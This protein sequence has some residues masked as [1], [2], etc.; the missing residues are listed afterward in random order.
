MHS[1]GPDPFKVTADS[2][3]DSFCEIQKDFASLKASLD[4]VILSLLLKVH[5]S[6][7]GI[8]KEDQPVLNVFTKCSRFTETALKLVSQS[9]DGSPLNTEEL[10]VCLVAEIKYQQDEYAALLVKGK[11]DNSTAQLFRALQKN[12]ATMCIIA[13]FIYIFTKIKVSA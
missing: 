12:S 8:K 6:R 11:F 3:E 5:D 9:K 7:S 13:R 4:K 1:V 2:P 10:I